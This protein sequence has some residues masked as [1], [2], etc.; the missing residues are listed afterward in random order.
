[1]ELVPE[2]LKGSQFCD[3][4]QRSVVM[5]AWLLGAGKAVVLLFCMITALTALAEKHDLE[6][7]GTIALVHEF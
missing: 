2:V 7:R 1:M 4:T 6:P 5:L 3:D